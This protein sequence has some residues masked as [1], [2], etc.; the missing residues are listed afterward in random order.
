MK[1]LITLLSIAIFAISCSKDDQNP[2]PV[3][4]PT[5]VV[6]NYSLKGLFDIDRNN[7]SDNEHWL[8]ENGRIFI[9]DEAGSI[10]ET[11]V[12]GGNL[13]NNSVSY[14]YDE[15]TKKLTFTYL[16]DNYEATYEPSTGKLINGT[17]KTGLITYFT[18]TGQKYLP[19]ENGVNLFKGH[20]KGVYTVG[21]GTILNSFNLIVENGSFVIASQY[22]NT[23]TNTVPSRIGISNNAPA[24]NDKTITGIYTYIGGTTFS[25]T[26]TYDPGTKKLVGTW[27]NGTSTTGGGTVSFSPENLN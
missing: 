10:K 19:T 16:G 7:T 13:G 2:A 15:T 18:F 14:V 26:A 5:P 6:V 27:G 24:I 17:I 1:K 12:A 20:W 4:T 22:T 11:I 8:L 9:G 21:T 25:F 23:L 3:P